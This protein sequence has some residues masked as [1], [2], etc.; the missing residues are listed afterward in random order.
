[1]K[2]NSVDEFRGFFERIK[3]AVNLKGGE[4]LQQ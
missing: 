1:M 4:Y 2:I 3:A